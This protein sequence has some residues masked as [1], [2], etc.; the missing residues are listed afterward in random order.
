[1]AVVFS[2]AGPPYWDHVVGGVNP[3]R[4]LFDHLSAV[5]AQMPLG[6]PIVQN[7]LW[8]RYTSAIQTPYTGISAMP[9]IHVAMPVLYALVGWRTW[10]PLGVAFAAYGVL[11]LVG[12]VHLGLAL[13][14]RRL[15][16]HRRRARAVVGGREDYL[17]KCPRPVNRSVVPGRQPPGPD[18]SYSTTHTPS[19]RRSIATRTLGSR[20]MT[21]HA[22]LMP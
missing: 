3:Y 15:C 18:L 17:E 5:A 20:R 9:S 11:I 13:R 12:S 2:S 10:K 8:A 1:M 16:Q 4:G 22:R 7:A 21:A 6:T 19:T 14:H